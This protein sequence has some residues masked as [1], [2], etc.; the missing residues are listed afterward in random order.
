M[1]VKSKTR[2][3][4]T[5]A[6][7]LLA[8][9][10]LA[11]NA[12]AQDAAAPVEPAAETKAEANSGEIIVT[13]QRRAS[14]LQDTPIAISY[15]GGEALA[16]TR[17]VTLRDLAGLAPNVQI[18]RFGA[19]PTTQQIYIRGIGEGDLIYNQKVGIYLDDMFI[20]GSVNALSDL[21]DVEHIEVLRG[22]Q[23]TL[24]GQNTSAGA[25][26]VVTR[27]PGD[28]RKIIA[29]IGAGNYDA[30]QAHVYVSTPLSDGLAAS[31]T[32]GHQEN[33]GYAYNATL[34]KRVNS[35]DLT[36]G[37]LK[38]RYYGTDGLDIELAGDYA[39]DK[40]ST[41][42]YSSAFQ[43]GGF[44]PNVTYSGVDPRNS[45]SSGGASMR[46]NYDVNDNL[47]ARSLSSYRGFD[48]DGDYD[49]QGT[50]AVTFN[51]ATGFDSAN[52][53]EYRNRS[54]T[55]EFQLNGDYD[56]L[57]F[58]T[59]LFYIHSKLRFERN[60]YNN[61]SIGNLPRN[62]FG[63]QTEDTIAAY[64]QL[65]Y[66]ITDA[67][68]VT[69]GVRVGH[70]KVRGT[71]RLSLED[72]N[73]VITSQLFATDNTAKFTRVT[74]KLG[75][76]YK[77]SP[78]LLFYANVSRGVNGGGFDTRA[79]NAIDAGTPFKP[80]IVTTYEG[81]VKSTLPDG[82]GSV[83]L[84]GFYN[85]FKDFQAGA[86]V[87]STGGLIRGN[88]GQAHTWG[89][90]FEGALRPVSGLEFAANAGYLDAVFDEYLNPTGPNTSAS[91]NRLPRAPKWTVSLSTNY[92]IPLGDVSSLRLGG[93][94]NYQ[95]KSYTDV[96]NT[97]FHASPG[98]TLFDA[99]ASYTID[100]NWSLTAN[101]RNITN[102]RVETAGSDTRFTSIRTYNDPRTYGLT[103]RLEY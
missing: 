3:S 46:I 33:H 51:G 52:F 76:E 48:Q 74:P 71:Y 45:S 97:E 78:D 30:K 13:A 61:F 63:T 39:I 27:R 7:S 34:R 55:Q 90:E 8:S 37:R 62:Q 93:N 26:R 94:M 80:E 67:L 88:A 82:L 70:Q 18:P 47:T 87:A 12:N 64:G 20:P 84:T 40:S 72:I 102:K 49:N 96:L 65:T 31:L 24:Y 101:I 66:K 81:G 85:E 23:G 10:A 68:S 56:N 16:N 73:R 5:L 91:D 22:P 98:V 69:G 1:K 6:A 58:A 60:F 79:V 15:F 11:A 89:I 21:F 2:L 44:D 4:Q 99:F 17:A 103:L 9:T 95:S 32:L 42:Q 43:P 75:L 29:D 59:G 53:V 86:F 77:A 57:D 83:N 19:T 38:L 100:P 35:L 28:E 54:F 14:S 25:I 41:R 50:P 92:E 36:T